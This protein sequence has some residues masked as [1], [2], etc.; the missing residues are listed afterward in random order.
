[1]ANN[2]NFFLTSSLAAGGFMAWDSAAGTL[3]IKGSI[4]ITG[5]QAATD[6]SNAASSGSNALTYAITNNATASVA[7][8]NLKIFTD[9]KLENFKKTLI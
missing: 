6:I 8:T 5:G 4:N 2:G 9:Y 3:Q 7:T 1:M